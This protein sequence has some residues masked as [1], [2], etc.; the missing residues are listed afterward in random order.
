[1]ASFLSYAWI[2]TESPNNDPN[3]SQRELLS[4]F[5]SLDTQK[6]M[7]QEEYTQFQNLDDVVTV[8]RGV[9]SY[10]ANNIK[11]LSW[12]LNREV[13]EWFVHRYGEDGISPGA[14]RYHGYAGKH[15]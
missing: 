1:M 9:T 5:R 8:Y 7:D 14:A 15:R 13:A 6:L 10:N 12:T 4:M 2:S 11:A 3:L